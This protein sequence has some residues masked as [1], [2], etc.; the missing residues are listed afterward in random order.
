MPSEQVTQWHGR[1]GQVEA[2]HPDPIVAG[3]VEVAPYQRAWPDSTFVRGEQLRSGTN[4]C[5]LQ[6]N[7]SAIR[8][9]F[10]PFPEANAALAL[11]F[12]FPMPNLGLAGTL[13]VK[14]DEC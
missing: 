3:L 13:H 4:H 2:S 9:N 11:T 1:A 10:E 5:N 8:T 6:G 12:S 7:S 14:T